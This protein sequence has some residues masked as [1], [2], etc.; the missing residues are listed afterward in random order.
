MRIRKTHYWIH[1]AALHYRE[2]IF[3]VGISIPCSIAQDYLP[4]EGYVSVLETIS[5]I[6]PL[7]PVVFSLISQHDVRKLRKTVYNA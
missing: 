5:Q 3:E 1:I 4:Y 7:A 6:A 2:C